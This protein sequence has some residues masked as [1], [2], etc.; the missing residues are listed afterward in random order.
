M[1]INVVTPSPPVD[2][3]QRE[4]EVLREQIQR[5]VAVKD[6]QKPSQELPVYT[7]PSYSLSACNHPANYNLDLLS[8]NC[9][10]SLLC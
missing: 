7:I 9:Q 3:K 8:A 4:V 10:I 5:L 6:P 1:P 2:Q